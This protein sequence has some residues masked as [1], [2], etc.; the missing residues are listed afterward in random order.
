MTGNVRVLREIIERFLREN[1]RDDSV[2]PA[3]EI[4]RDVANGF[5]LAQARQ[6]VVE[7]HR[8][9]AQAGDADFKSDARAQRGLFEN[10]RQERGRQSAVRYRSGCALISAARRKK[11]RSCAGF[12]SMPVRRS[13]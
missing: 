4:F 13:F 10:Q 1:A 12:H 11:S 8:R 5:A 7:K 9:A 3:F 6:R 2:H